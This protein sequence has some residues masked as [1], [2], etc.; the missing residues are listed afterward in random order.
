M[1]I[2]KV[3]LIVHLSA[4]IQSKML[5]PI[6]VSVRTQSQPLST[7]S[8]HL[9]AARSLTTKSPDLGDFDP[10]KLSSTLEKLYVWEKRLHKIIQVNLYY[11]YGEVRA[12]RMGLFFA[13]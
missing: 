10:G 11:T 7:N 12:R 2:I 13:L 3:N 5:V 6:I 1:S 4:A 8:Q 9:T